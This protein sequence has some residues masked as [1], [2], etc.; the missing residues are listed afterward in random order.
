MSQSGFFWSQLGPA[1]HQGQ[2]SCHILA[3]LIAQ[4]HLLISPGRWRQAAWCQSCVI[5]VPTSCFTCTEWTNTHPEE[6]LSSSGLPSVH[7]SAFGLGSEEG[8]SAVLQG[9]WLRAQRQL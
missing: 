5:I 6:L 1:L 4:G 3:L 9:T 2:A 7:S 8:A